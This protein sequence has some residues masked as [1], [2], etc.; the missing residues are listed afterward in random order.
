VI[1][2]R[3]SRRYPA[4]FS[5]DGTRVVTCTDDGKSQVWEARSGKL[6]FELKAANPGRYIGAG[7]S[8]DGTRIVTF[9]SNG[10]AKLWDGQTGT[11]L[12]DL[13]GSVDSNVKFSPDGSK[14]CSCSGNNAEILDARNGDR[15]LIL[16]GHAGFVTSASFSPDMKRIVTSSWDGTA[17][18][19]DSQS[20]TPLL[21]LN[22]HARKVHL[23]LFSPDGTRVFT[24]HEDGIVRIWDTSPTLGLDDLEYHVTWTLPDPNYH[25]ANLVSA[26]AGQNRFAA[27]F[28][29]D[30]LLAYQPWQ[31]D[32][33]LAERSKL[34]CDKCLEARTAFHTPSV[35]SQP[36]WAAIA[37]MAAHGDGL[38]E[39]LIAQKLI[40][41]GSPGP[42]LPFLYLSLLGRRFNQP[43][44]E[45]FLI[46]QALIDLKKPDEAK[47]YYQ[48]AVDWMDKARRPLQ[49]ANIVTSAQNGGWQAIAE[50]H[51][52]VNDPRYNE[53]DWESW[54]ECDIFRARVEK[55]FQ[56]K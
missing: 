34:K 49:I 18:V 38:A 24:I 45:E 2:S 13:K 11:W 6:V 33:L 52:M 25:R 8:L 4:F 42:A 44:I 17:K 50:L 54:Y 7:F 21:D 14:I 9:P 55:S 41:D 56:P 43:P 1:Q 29:I 30:R 39:R 37:L 10:V 27:A 32:S 31:R 15:L 51:P 22:A 40:A 35:K 26:I 28:Q 12:F 3:S 16:K 46:A 47:R 48:S 5:S 19:W 20:A 23:A 36:D 53:F